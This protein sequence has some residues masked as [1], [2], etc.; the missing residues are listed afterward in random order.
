NTNISNWDTSNAL[1]FS[2]MFS[3]TSF[4]QDISNWDVS[5]ATV[6]DYMFESKHHILLQFKNTHFLTFPLNHY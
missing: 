6:F 4:N 3:D 2:Y 5:Y 1:D